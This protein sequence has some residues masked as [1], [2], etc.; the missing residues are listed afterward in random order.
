[1]KKEHA[2]NA[3]TKAEETSLGEGRPST[4]KRRMTAS[5]KYEAVLRVIKG[6]DAEMVARSIGVTAA[7]VSD[8]YERALEASLHIFESP[9]RDAQDEEIDR[10]STELDELTATRA[11]LEEKVEK[12][13]AGR[14]PFVRRKS[15]R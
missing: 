2:E 6:E 12:L 13:E 9:D 5:R 1:M 11:I 7:E 8:W 10:L 14:P 3:G 15:K 4:R